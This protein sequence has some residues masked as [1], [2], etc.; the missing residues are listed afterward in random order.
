MRIRNNLAIGLVSLLGFSNFANSSVLYNEYFNNG[1]P[2]IKENDLENVCE[3][4]RLENLDFLYV[5]SDGNE[6]LMRH[7]KRD[8]RIYVGKSY[9]EA[10]EYKS[11][12][13]SI[14]KIDET[15]CSKALT[16]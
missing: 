9:E 5:L 1:V 14:R 13:Y 3:F 8:I 12:T 15:N 16:L 2:Q 11:K 4:M 10:T 6:N 7:P